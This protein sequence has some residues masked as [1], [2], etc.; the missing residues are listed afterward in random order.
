MDFY[1]PFPF[2]WEWAF[3]ILF[4]VWTLGMKFSIPFP[5]PN[6]HKSF[7]L[8][9]NGNWSSN[10]VLRAALVSIIMF[11]IMGYLGWVGGSICFVLTLYTSHPLNTLTLISPPALK[12]PFIYPRPSTILTTCKPGIKC[13]PLQKKLGLLNHR[14]NPWESSQVTHLF[15]NRGLPRG[16]E[17]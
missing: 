2:L 1:I 4:P 6:P 13:W 12:R 5:F 16:L 8:T 11:S 3:S 7:P 17:K 10:R 9:P 15:P 14:S